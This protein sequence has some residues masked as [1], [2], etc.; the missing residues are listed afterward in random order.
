MRHQTHSL[1]VVQGATGVGTAQKTLDLV[2]KW[3]QVDGIAGG[4]VIELQGRISATWV[5]LVVLNTD[6]LVEVPEAVSWVRTNRT[7]QGTGNPTLTL[8]GRDA[9]SD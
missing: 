6:T 7:T 2:D 1:N 4:C 5:V 8:A 3:L 9:R